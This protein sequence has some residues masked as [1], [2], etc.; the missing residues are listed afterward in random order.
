MNLREHRALRCQSHSLT[1]TT[2]SSRA[3]EKAEGSKPYETKHLNIYTA[4]ALCQNYVLKAWINHTSLIHVS[5]DKGRVCVQQLFQ[6]TPVFKI[7]LPR[8]RWDAWPYKV[9]I[10]VFF[11]T[12]SRLKSRKC[13]T[14]TKHDVFWAWVRHSLDWEKCHSGFALASP[15]LLNMCNMFL[16]QKDKPTRGHSSSFTTTMPLYVA[17]SFS[18][19]QHL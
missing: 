9:S 19:S 4:E 11:F 3:K 5:T 13:S 14:A 18:R 1:T 2:N 7:L 6:N 15:F 12:D 17:E 10:P 8:F 16:G